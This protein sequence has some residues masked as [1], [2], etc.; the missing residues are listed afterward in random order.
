MKADL[1]KQPGQETGVNV[2]TTQYRIVNAV[3]EWLSQ[4]RTQLVTVISF[5]VLGR[6]LAGIFDYVPLHGPLEDGYITAYKE[7]IRSHKP[8]NAYFEDLYL[9]V[10]NNASALAASRS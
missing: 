6:F 3:Q 4:R 9:Q 1:E 8:D 7:T 2:S 5:I 10:P